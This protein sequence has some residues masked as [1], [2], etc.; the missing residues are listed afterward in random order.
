MQNPKPATHNPKP[1]THDPEPA[2][3]NPEPRNGK[4][5][6][7]LKFALVENHNLYNINRIFV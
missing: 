7:H 6:K 5:K 2:T 1:A 4:L 3:H